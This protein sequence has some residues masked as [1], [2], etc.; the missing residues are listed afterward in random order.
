M[1]LYIFLVPPLLIGDGGA[2]ASFQAVAIFPDGQTMDLWV[3]LGVVPGATQ[4]QE[5]NAILNAVKRTAA[6]QYPDVVFPD[7]PNA[8]RWFG[9]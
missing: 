2:R 5:R 6:E 8:I 9:V 4:A 1:N 7:T 3:Q